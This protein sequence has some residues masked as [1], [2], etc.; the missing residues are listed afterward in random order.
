VERRDEDVVMRVTNTTRAELQRG[1]DGV[2][3]RNV[4]T[5]LEV[6][7]GARAS[8]R[9]G[10]DGEARWVTEIRLPM[11]RGAGGPG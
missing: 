11:L 6:Q 4:R 9:A 10:P 2:G 7:F 5:R 3:L 1:P 8:F